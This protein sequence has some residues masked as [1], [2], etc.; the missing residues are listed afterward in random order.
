LIGQR[1][2]RTGSQTRSKS[3]VSHKRGRRIQQESSSLF[4]EGDKMEINK[5]ECIGTI[6]DY[7]NPSCSSLCHTGLHGGGIASMHPNLE[8]L[9]IRVYVD[10]N[11][12]EHPL[13]E[14][15]N[16]APGK[17]KITIE[18]IEDGRQAV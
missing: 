2:K 6:C 18:R 4:I 10:R 3:F 14:S 1:K 8:T 9:N 16:L 17:Y 11:H 15:L 12:F 13:K 5:I 7:N